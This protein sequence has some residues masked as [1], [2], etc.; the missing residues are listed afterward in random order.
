M[1]IIPEN[2]ASNVLSP[3]GATVIPFSQE[4]LQELQSGLTQTPM[5]SL[6]CPR[7]QCTWKPVSTF[8]EQSLRFPQ[9]C[10]APVHKPHWPSTPNAPGAPPPYARSPGLRTWRGAQNSHSY[11]CVS[12]IQLVSSLW[13][14]HLAAM[15]LFILHNW[16][17]YHLDVASPLSPGGGYLFWWFVY[18]VEGCSAIGSNFVGFMRED[19]LQSIYSTILIPSSLLFYF[20]F[21]GFVPSSWWVWPEVRQF[22]LTFQTTSSWV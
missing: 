15:G 4:I 21:I 6:L 2:F 8:Q 16:P 14:T 5:E 13:A 1:L 11:R 17:F 9:S 3:E 10:G 22:S 20:L 18:L 19:N 7:T 12:V